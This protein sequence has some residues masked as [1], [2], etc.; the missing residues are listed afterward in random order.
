MVELYKNTIRVDLSD[1]VVQMQAY[2]K[3]N[4]NA[5]RDKYI[6]TT[7]Y[8]RTERDTSKSRNAT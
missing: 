1:H 7:E 5:E 2:K 8:I 3:K 6:G 4:E